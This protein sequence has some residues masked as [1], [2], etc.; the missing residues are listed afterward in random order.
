M[1]KIRTYAPN[2]DKLFETFDWNCGSIQNESSYTDDYLSVLLDSG[3]LILRDGMFSCGPDWDFMSLPGEQRRWGFRKMLSKSTEATE[4]MS[5]IG[6]GGK[7]VDLLVGTDPLRRVTILTLLAWMESLDMVRLQDGLYYPN[8]SYDL[9][10]DEEF[11]WQ[12]EIIN[13]EI[14]IKDDKYSVFEYLR[15]INKGLVLLNPDFQR[16]LVWKYSQ[17]S[18]FIESILMNLPIPP[19]YLKKESSGKYI[20]V[21]GLQRTSALMEFMAN[22]FALDGLDSLYKLNGCRFQDLDSVQDGLSARLE[23][24]QLYF[25]VMLPSVPMHIVYDVF[26]R[27]NTGGT[28]LTRQEIRNCVFPGPATALLKEIAA[29]DEFVRAIDGG[30][31]PLRM[32]DREAVLRC[33]AYIVVPNYKDNYSG[34]LDDFLEKAMRALNKMKLSEIDSLKYSTLSCYNL[35]YRI[36]GN[37]NFR[38]PT[39]Y[40]R[41]RIN[42]AVMETVFHC[43][44]GVNDIPE[45][46][47]Q[48]LRTTMEQLLMDEDYYSAVVASTG[49]TSQVMTRFQKAHDAFDNYLKR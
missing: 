9:S 47:I 4:L 42:I 44:Y 5:V 36:F 34:S 2:L 41:G 1:L 12:K 46:S 30:I 15:K 19:I 6:E 11:L 3:A 17:K 25:Y 16:N 8:L 18:K 29:S 24:R 14:D 48:I 49:S 31:R 10:S 13:V 43:F 37:T 33:L 20:V 40:T 32:K 27:I 22:E 7:D 38:I 23:D 26:N 39:D 21:D 45:E 35:T 28:Q